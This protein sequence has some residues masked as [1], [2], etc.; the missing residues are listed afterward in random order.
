MIGHPGIDHQSAPAWVR[1][2]ND[3]RSRT[4]VDLSESLTFRTLTVGFG[5]LLTQLLGLRQHERQYPL[6]IAWLTQRRN[7]PDHRLFQC[8]IETVYSLDHHGRAIQRRAAGLTREH[9][10]GTRRR[11]HTAGNIG[12]EPGAPVA[13]VRLAK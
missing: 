2:R 9:T 4:A 12:F 5:V 7:R 10:V 3:R 8:R 13:D 1:D 6:L 11:W